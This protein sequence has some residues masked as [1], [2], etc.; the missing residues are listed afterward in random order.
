MLVSHH[1]RFTTTSVFSSLNAAAFTAAVDFFFCT[2]YRVTGIC[3]GLVSSGFHSLSLLISSLSVP[4]ITA[5]PM[6]G[7]TL[8]RYGV[9]AHVYVR[10]VH[11][12]STIC[13]TGIAYR[14]LSGLMVLLS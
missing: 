13:I 1:Y 9:C 5:V 6:E 14:N 11:G 4:A 2:S 3:I 10:N 7:A 8:T 12:L